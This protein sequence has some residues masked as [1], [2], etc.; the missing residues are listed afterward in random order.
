MVH[1]LVA[2]LDLA[3]RLLAPPLTSEAEKSLLLMAEAPG[4]PPDWTNES[5]LVGV[6]EAIAELHRRTARPDGTVLCHGDLHRANLLWDGRRAILLD[7]ALAR[8]DGPLADLARLWPW[9]P[10]GGSIDR[11]C[12]LPTGEAAGL[13]LALYHR[14][15]PLA[16]LSWPEFQLR[17]RAAAGAL[18][19]AERDRHERAERTASA[20]LRPWIEAARLRVEGALQQLD[21]AFPPIPC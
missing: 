10:S 17:H 4:A 12:D 21:S 9:A 14:A 2:R 1:R 8:R 19:R 20:G 3:P 7:W 11:G 16:H 5:A 15:G 18:L 13:A 6:T